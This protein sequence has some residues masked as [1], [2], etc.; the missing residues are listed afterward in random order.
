MS[1]IFYRVVFIAS[2]F[3]CLFT[4]QSIAQTFDSWEW[5][6]LKNIEAGRTT[7]KTKFYS[8]VSDL[9][10][11]IALGIPVTTAIVGFIKNDK[12]LKNKALYLGESF[13]ASAII[14]HSLKKIINKQRPAAA[15]PNFIALRNELDQSFPSG[16]TSEAFSM[17]TSV[18]LTYPK[19]YVIAPSFTFATLVGYSRMYLGVHYPTDVIAGAILGSGTAYLCHKANKWINKKSK[20]H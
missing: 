20:K 4:S 3:I 18:S 10:D 17:A 15:N 7:S 5:K 2:T 6:W 1:T 11:P 19:W 12:D 8:T 13:V 16:H 14:T 9:S